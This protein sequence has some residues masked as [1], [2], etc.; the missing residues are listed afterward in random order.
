MSTAIVILIIVAAVIVVALAGVA[1]YFFAERE[2]SKH[3]QE[4]FR[5]EYDRTVEGTGDRRRAESELASRQKRVEELNI[6]ELSPDDRERFAAQW[7]EVQADFVD[8]PERAIAASDRLVNDVMQRRGYPMG[9]FEQRAADVSV[10]HPD[11]VE[12]YRKAHAIAGS[13]AARQASTED[14]REAMIHY[15]ALFDDLLGQQ[16]ARRRAS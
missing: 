6:R 8:D 3:L 15:R 13:E 16:P 7:D 9:E 2:R 1:I 5:G 11:V 14:L 4:T 10:D 12:H